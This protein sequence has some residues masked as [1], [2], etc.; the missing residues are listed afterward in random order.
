MTVANLLDNISSEELSYWMAYYKLK[1]KE[2]EAEMKKAQ[3]TRGRG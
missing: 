1:R 3:K 2:E